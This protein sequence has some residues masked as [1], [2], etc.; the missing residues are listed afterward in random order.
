MPAATLMRICRR[1]TYHGQYEYVPVACKQDI[2]PGRAADDMADTIFLMLSYARDIIAPSSRTVLRPPPSRIATSMMPGRHCQDAGN[3]ARV[4]SARP[5]PMRISM[6]LPAPAAMAAGAP[7]AAEVMR[8]FRADA[9]D[10]CEERGSD[11]R[12][13]TRWNSMMLLI[14]RI[15]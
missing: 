6:T 11:N 5:S 7:F 13:S 1:S 9:D 4:T 12:L 15:C 8:G 2:R 14:C 3:Y 10:F